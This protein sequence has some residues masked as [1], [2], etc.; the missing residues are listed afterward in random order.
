MKEARDEEADHATVWPPRPTDQVENTRVNTVSRYLTSYV[1]LDTIVGISGGLFSYW[2]AVY[3]ITNYI[4]YYLVPH[5]VGF[6]WN[7]VVACIVALL[8]SVLV[9]IRLHTLYRRLA[10]S[11]LFTSAVAGMVTVYAFHLG[12]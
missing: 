5:T 12:T 4:L 7:I 10:N 8:A 9:W 2:F 3:A 6:F 11:I 1:W